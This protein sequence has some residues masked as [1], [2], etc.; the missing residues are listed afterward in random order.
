VWVAGRDTGEG[1]FTLNSWL[2]RRILAPLVFRVVFHRLLTI[3]T[4]MGR[5]A[6]PK[7]LS[8]GGPL[9]RTRWSDLLAAGVQRSERIERVQDGLPQRADGQPLEVANV[10]WCTGFHPGFSWIKLPI[11]DEQG[12]P[13]HDGG[14]VTSQP[15]LYFVG[16]NFLY[17][18]SST[19][20]HGVGRDANRIV[21]VL[22]KRVSR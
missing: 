21:K 11:F 7:V 5:K 22:A 12:A 6:R 10:I 3:R 17:S 20:I 13:R 15:G 2:A 4:P 18:F 16:L 1:P 14:V 19:M 9:I 8:S